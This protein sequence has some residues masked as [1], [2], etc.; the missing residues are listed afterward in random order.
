MT[1]TRLSGKWSRVLLALVAWTAMVYFAAISGLLQSTFHSPQLSSV[2]REARHAPAPQAPSRSKDSDATTQSPMASPSSVSTQ[3]PT[4]LQFSAPTQSPTSFSAPTQPPTPAPSSAPSPAVSFSPP[5]L[6]PTP[7]PTYSYIQ[8]DS[9]N[10]TRLELAVMIN[11]LHRLR[12]AA[13]LQNRLGVPVYVLSLGGERLAQF[14]REMKAERQPS[15]VR[16]PQPPRDDGWKSDYAI[17][18]KDGWGTKAHIA[19]AQELLRRGDSCAMVAEDDAT[20]GMSPH[21][22]LSLRELCDM[23]F[24]KDPDWTAV[25]LY[26][27]EMRTPESGKVQVRKHTHR[28]FGGVAYLATQRWARLL[29]R[30]TANNTRLMKREVGSSYG[31]ADSVIYHMKNSSAWVLRPVYVFP[32]NVVA[33][34]NTLPNPHSCLLYTS[35]SPRDS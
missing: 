6:S 5:P 12:E 27:T 15:F 11:K 26:S 29:V 10:G 22:P 23:M 1:D 34:S 32:N 9:M 16:V 18:Q 21:W 2:H 8:T 35:P 14:A 4:A 19:A 7:V 31:I 13:P 30:V 25:A 3:F 20:F 28:T 24:A 17:S 33:R